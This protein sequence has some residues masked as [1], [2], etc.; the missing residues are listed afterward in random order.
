MFS[1]VTLL[2]IYVI[3]GI[4]FIC[5]YNILLVFFNFFSSDCSYF[6]HLKNSKKLVLKNYREPL[7]YVFQTHYRFKKLEK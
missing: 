1:L 5:R 3:D 4:V 6:F 7:K 2:T